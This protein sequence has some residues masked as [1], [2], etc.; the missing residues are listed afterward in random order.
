MNKYIAASY[1]NQKKKFLKSYGT[2]HICGDCMHTTLCSRM[3][4]QNSGF[5]K[6]KKIAMLKK[7][8]PFI[9]DYEIETYQ[10]KGQLN[11]INFVKVYKCDKF[12]FDGGQE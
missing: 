7:L 4:V 8:A 9:T 1:E 3:K 6:E 10:P 12:V 11:P 5:N 2:V